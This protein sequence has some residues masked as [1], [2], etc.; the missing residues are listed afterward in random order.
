MPERG[1]VAVFNRSYYEEVLVVRVHPEFLAAQSLP[2][3]PTPQLWADRL[4]AIAD[5]ER[6]LAEQGT[7]IVKFWLNVSKREQRKRLLDRIEKPDKNWKFNAADLDERDRWD[8]YLAAF[9]DCLNATSRPW[10]PWYAV[11]ADDK[12]Y[13]RWQVARIVHETLEQL[14]VDFPRVDAAARAAMAA[15]K[16]RLLA[17]RDD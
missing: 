14:G 9:A 4:R 17:E 1:S 10:A 16:K 8:D 5:H 15:A 3:P 2:E 7:V 11:P 6:H 13:M 12:H